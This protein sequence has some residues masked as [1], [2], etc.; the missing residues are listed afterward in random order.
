MFAAVFAACGGSADSDE[1]ERLRGEIQELQR[2]IA[3]PLPPA[4]AKATVRPISEIL[5]GEI[6]IVDL[7]STSAAVRVD[8]TLDVVCSVAYGLD[9]S[10]GA[11][12]TD[13][14]MG[15]AAHSQHRAIMRGL[16]QDTLYHYRLQGA[17][18]DGTLYVSNDLTFRTLPAPRT[19]ERGRNLATAAAGATVLAVST[20]FADD[21]RW[22]G[23]N[24]I[25]G[26]PGTEWSSAGDGDAAFIEVELAGPSTLSAIGLWTRTMGSS[27]QITRFRVVADGATVLGPFDV[28]DAA[29]M[30]TYEVSITAR[31]LRFEVVSSSGGNTGVVELAAFAAQ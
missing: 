25:D 28:P 29:G 22:D 17:G 7:S 20:V 30:H 19:A 16:Q 15:G 13:L 9:E 10:Y 31:R 14:D 3:T 4:A 27:A 24:A 5:K 23:D 6:E 8:T 12:T 21:A 1:I 11:L 26:D 2:R 18:P